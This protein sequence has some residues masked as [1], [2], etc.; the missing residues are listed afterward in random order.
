M[1]PGFGGKSWYEWDGVRIGYESLGNGL[2]FIAISK[3]YNNDNGEFYSDLFKTPAEVELFLNESKLDTVT[4]SNN[5]QL[6][7]RMEYKYKT[8]ELLVD[9]PDPVDLT[10]N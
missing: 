6:K 5:F 1:L 2:S 8:L 4:P 10:I 3:P 9:N 7:F